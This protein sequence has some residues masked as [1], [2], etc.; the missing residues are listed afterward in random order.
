MDKQS[1]KYFLS[2][3]CYLFTCSSFLLVWY[4][5]DMWSFRENWTVLSVFLKARADL[6]MTIFKTI[7][8]VQAF[9]FG[10]QMLGLCQVL[11]KC[12]AA[13]K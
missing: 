7:T 12:D 9:I 1:L 3:A 8:L 11:C 6:C 13:L 10:N 2:Y 4:L 5:M